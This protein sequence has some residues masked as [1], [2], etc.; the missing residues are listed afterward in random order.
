MKSIE[1]FITRLNG[2][3]SISLETYLSLLFSQEENKFSKIK[4]PKGMPIKAIEPDST[5]NDELILSPGNF[6]E[7]LIKQNLILD[8]NNKNGQIQISNLSN[9][10][11]SLKEYDV[12]TRG[13]IIS[14]DTD[15]K[16]LFIEIN[17][18]IEIIDDMSLVRPLKEIR[19][20][21][22][23]F[24]AYYIKQISNSGYNSIKEEFD[25]LMNANSNNNKLFY[26]KYDIIKSSLLCFGNKNDLNNLLLLNKQEEKY[27]KNNNNDEQNNNSDSNPNSNNNLLGVKGPSRESEDS[28]KKIIIV[29]DEKQNE[30]NEC[31]YKTSFT[32]REKFKK[33]LEKDFAE[34]FQNCR[35]YIGKNNDNNFDVVVYG[36][37]EDEYLKEKNICE[38]KYKQVK[39][40]SDTPLNKNELNDLAMKSK[41]KYINIEKK[42]IY[43]VGEEKCIN[44]FK[45]VWEMTKKYSKEIQKT[46]KENESI[47]RELQTFKKKHN[48]K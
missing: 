14:N 11:K 2:W 27:K 41:V 42:N 6:V 16:L 26:I 25:K 8:T 20:T 7:V 44:N 45:T 37:N 9:D 32:Y 12:W 15:S 1:Y 38:K 35:Y 33:D 47:Q 43:L 5:N 13:K 28:D 22:S 23:D 30:I 17:D 10:Q 40:D 29:D 48:L 19:T 31:K 36:N 4:I 21:S 18:K 34:I 46:S 3:L 24:V 39:L